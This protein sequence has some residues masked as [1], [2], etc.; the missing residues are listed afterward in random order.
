MNTDDP[1]YTIDLSMNDKGYIESALNA[2]WNRATQE[3]STGYR[4]DSG[5]T[6]LPLG[7]LEREFNEKTIIKTKELMDRLDNCQMI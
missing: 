3:N 4:L 7:D 6:K 1:A 2:E 5:G